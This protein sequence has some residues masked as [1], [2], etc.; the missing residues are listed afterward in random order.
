MKNFTLFALLLTLVALGGSCF[1][2]CNVRCE[3]AFRFVVSHEDYHLSGVVSREPF[4]GY[5]RFG[6][7]SHAHPEAV[8]AGFYRMSRQRALRY[9]ERLF[10]VGYWKPMHADQISSDRLAFKL[11]DL[12]YNLGPVRATILLQ[13]ALN[14]LGSDLYAKGYFGGGT[15]DALQNG[16]P[17]TVTMLVKYQA[18]G[19]YTRLSQKNPVAAKKWKQIWL[20]RLGEEPV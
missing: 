7:N 16:P 6:V 18:A 20:D 1:A 15:M 19:F 14:L 10:Y 4:G 8:R 12:A 13:R 5:A 3:T 9:A 17:Q 11:V 2:Q